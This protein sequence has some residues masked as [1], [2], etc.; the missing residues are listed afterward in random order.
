VITALAVRRFRLKA[1][2]QPCRQHAFGQVP[3]E[4]ASQ[5]GF[6]GYRFGILVL[7]PGQQ[8]ASQSIHPG[9]VVGRRFPGLPC[10]VHRFGHKISLPVLFHD[11]LH[12]KNLTGSLK[13][14]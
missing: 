3:L 12:T 6:A 7:N 4:L 9:M 8:P 1:M 10:R 11:L 5:A 13:E 14:I 2:D